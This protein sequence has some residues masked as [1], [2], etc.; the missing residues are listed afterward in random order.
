M[1]NPSL[2]G[3]TII[4]LHSTVT[5]DEQCMVMQRPQS[6]YRKVY[7]FFI[8]LFIFLTFVND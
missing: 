6:G 2:P 5:I 3:I 4:K 1:S 7:P 8:P